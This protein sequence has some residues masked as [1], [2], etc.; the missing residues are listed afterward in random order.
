M[1][2]ADRT[3]HVTSCLGPIQHSSTPVR[4]TS[5]RKDRR[6]YRRCKLAGSFAPS[7]PSSYKHAMRLRAGEALMPFSVRPFRRFPL[8]SSV[9]Y[10]QRRENPARVGRAGGVI[11]LL[12]SYGTTAR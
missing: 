9:T 6:E 4:P 1:G 7:F 8:Q 12:K 5:P 3:A 2:G 11:K 10:N